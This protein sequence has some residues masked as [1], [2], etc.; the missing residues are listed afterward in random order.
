MAYIPGRVTSIFG[1]DY[2]NGSLTYVCLSAVSTT[3]WQY[4]QSLLVR[5]PV[6]NP[7]EKAYSVV[8]NAKKMG[9]SMPFLY[10]GAQFPYFRRCIKPGLMIT[11]SDFWTVQM[12]ILHFNV[13]QL[14]AVCSAFKTNSTQKNSDSIRQHHCVRLSEQTKEGGGQMYLLVWRILAYCNP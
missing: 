2:T 8:E 12:Y 14:K 11:V 6:S 5:I 10:T 3:N 7:S 9:N 1:K 13:L 4:L